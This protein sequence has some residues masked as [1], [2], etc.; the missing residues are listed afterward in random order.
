M[1]A[2]DTAPEE[3]AVLGRLH[4][5]LLTHARTTGT[6]EVA[7]SIIDSPLGRLLLAATPE[8]LVR[9]AFE[10]EDFD[11]VLGTLA[12]KIGPR[13]LR[14]AD[15][16]DRAAHELDEYFAGAR[17][18]FDLTLDRR[19]TTPF[20][21]EVQ[22]FLPSIE[23]GH[24]LSYRDV[25]EALGRP[26]AMRAV[27]TACATN[28]LPIVVPCHRVLRTDGQLGGYIGGLDAKRALLEA[29]RGRA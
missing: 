20:R 18:S 11:T 7:Y 1:T 25:A 10:R 29:E 3:A 12:E 16:V 9:V 26:R 17:R 19:L 15:P 21:G 13:I 14:D 24:T 27:G 4:G 23:F 5:N 28:P 8:G 2:F 22:R 6:R